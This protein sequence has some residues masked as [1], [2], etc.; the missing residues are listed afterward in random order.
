MP[1]YSP[2]PRR[3]APARQA[4]PASAARPQDDLVTALLAVR[5]ADVSADPGYLRSMRLSHLA[6]LTAPVWIP[7]AVVV[8][9][10][11]LLIRATS[12]R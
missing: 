1:E 10:L 11:R 3:R 12:P 6:V 8:N 5:E 2:G 4:A 7:F 9:G